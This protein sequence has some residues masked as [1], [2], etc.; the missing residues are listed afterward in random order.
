MYPGPEDFIDVDNKDG[1][2][3]KEDISGE[4]I[5]PEETAGFKFDPIYKEIPAPTFETSFMIPHDVNEQ[6]Y[7]V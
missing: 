6:N 3:L 1:I 7:Q 4:A 2:V 5:H